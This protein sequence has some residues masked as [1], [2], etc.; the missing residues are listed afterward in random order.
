MAKLYFRFGSMNSGKSTA[1]IQVAF[2]YQERGMKALIIKPKVDTK[3]DYVLSRI[4]VSIS[5]DLTSTSDM[6]IS[7]EVQKKLHETAINC[8]LVDEAQF[9]EPSQ[10]DEL[11]H[12]AVQWNIPVIAYGIRTDFQTHSFPGSR[13]LMEVAHRIEE[14]KTICE[15]GEKAIF[16]ARK[17]GDAFVQEGSVVAID[18]DVEYE[19][20]CGQCYIEKVGPLW[21]GALGS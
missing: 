6:S 1:L 12:I 13:R 4:G 17:I 14:L 19:S 5:V 8:I 15:C 7:H 21:K 11:F 16:N 10:V 2:N 9:L 18:G 20:L 3:S